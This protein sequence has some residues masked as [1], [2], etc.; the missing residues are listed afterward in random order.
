MKPVISVLD[1]ADRILDLGFSTAMKYILENLP[2][3][4]Q[5]LL[6]SATLSTKNIMKL[7]NLSLKVLI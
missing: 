5:T 4:R 2:T 7:A 1:E 3:E 6:F